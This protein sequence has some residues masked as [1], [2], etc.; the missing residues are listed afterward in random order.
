MLINT[1][2]PAAKPLAPAHLAK[3]GL[4]V[5]LFFIGAGLPA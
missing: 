5:T 1:F 2:V 3:M 4:T